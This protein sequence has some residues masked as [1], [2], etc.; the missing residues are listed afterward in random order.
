MRGL[1]AAPDLIPDGH[2]P[3]PS[4]F[5]QQRGLKGQAVTEGIVHKEILISILHAADGKADQPLAFQRAVRVILKHF[6]PADNARLADT[7]PF[8][9]EHG[10]KLPPELLCRVVTAGHKGDLPGLFALFGIRVTPDGHLFCKCVL[11]G[12]EI[13]AQQRKS[14]HDF[15]LSVEQEP[16]GLQGQQLRRIVRQGD[17]CALCTAGL[18]Q[19]PAGL[20]FPPQFYAILEQSEVQ[21]QSLE[22]VA[23]LR[24]NVPQ[25]SQPASAH[26]GQTL[27]L[28]LCR[29]VIVAIH[30]QQPPRCL[31]ISQALFSFACIGR[32]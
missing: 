9:A 23:A 12:E 10:R 7:L 17:F 11:P 2:C 26:R 31:C 5:S 28:G 14:G 3:A 16:P 21:H 1:L 18:V 25:L 20:I 22:Q 29:G 32:E 24:L 4:Q 19:L 15:P 30:T 8:L 27:A 13:A 6:H